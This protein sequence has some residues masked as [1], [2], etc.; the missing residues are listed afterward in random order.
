MIFFPSVC[1]YN[2]DYAQAGRIKRLGKKT[3]KN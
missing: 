2:R 1:G 3:D